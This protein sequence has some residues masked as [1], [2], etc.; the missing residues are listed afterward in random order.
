MTGLSL[1]GM[2]P[3]VAGGL[4]PR[5][6]RVQAMADV[7]SLAQSPMRLQG[8]L[9]TPLMTCDGTCARCDLDYLNV[10]YHHRVVTGP[11]ALVFAAL[12]WEDFPEA[13]RRR[14]IREVSDRVPTAPLVRRAEDNGRL[15]G[16][17]FWNQYLI[18]WN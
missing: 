9:G 18:D 8:A 12:R 14:L 13:V 6:L 2:M 17:K 7:R 4:D 10:C 5:A 11:T 16:E 1:I 3:L 15:I